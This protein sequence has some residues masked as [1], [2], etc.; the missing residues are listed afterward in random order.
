[1]KS[2]AALE[3]III[4]FRKALEK[5]HVKESYIGFRH[6]PRGS[7]SD[8]SDLLGHYLTDNGLGRFDLVSG[9]NANGQTHAWL[10]NNEYIIDIT[11]DQFENKSE[12]VIIREASLGDNHLGFIVRSR[13]TALLACTGNMLL[14]DL[15]RA[16]NLI[17]QE[18][19]HPAN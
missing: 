3:E 12:K 7:C 15:L 6:F 19:N 14:F 2:K 10:E 16:Y 18:M 8:S 9:E 4:K 1:M 11:A 17:V 13:R 5:P